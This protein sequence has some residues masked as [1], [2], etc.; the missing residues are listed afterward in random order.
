MMADSK[1]F[2][3]PTSKAKLERSMVF[4]PNASGSADAL[5]GIARNHLNHG[6]PKKQSSTSLQW[7]NEFASL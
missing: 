3:R 2:H 5:V 4:F 7:L 6:P 1:P